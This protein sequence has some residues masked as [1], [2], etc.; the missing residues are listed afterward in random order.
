MPL[1]AERYFVIA[2]DLRG[3][4]D[5]EKPVGPYD[6]RTIAGD[7]AALVRHLGLAE[8]GAVGHD[9][10]GAVA[11][12]LAHD[13]PGLVARLMILDVFP[14]AFRTG[15]PIAHEY[16]LALHHMLFLGGRPDQAAAMVSRDI[17]E[18][19]RR[20][21]TGLD[22]NYRPDVFTESEIAEYVRSYSI[23]GSVRAACQWYAATLRQ[24]ADNLAGLDHRLT[25]PVSAWGASH[26]L[27]DI[28]WAWEPVAEQVEGGIFERCGHFI[29][30]E[31][32]ELAAA[33]I[34]EFF[35]P[36]AGDTA[37]SPAARS[38]TAPETPGRST[39][40]FA[41]RTLS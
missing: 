19:L 12:Y 30:E 9:L 18:Y 15:E 32:P 8:V 5:S 11:F 38:D 1:L 40:L 28:R 37:G 20:F 6:K 36:L 35:A 27:G 14:N 31:Q 17:G 16:A 39:T 4:G 22:L 23:P 29:A 25:V 10:G 24:D 33:R 41:E 34:T 13:N 21:L 26:C 7:V 2:P 3:L